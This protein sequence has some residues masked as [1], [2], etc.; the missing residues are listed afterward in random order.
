VV[1]VVCVV[2]VWC[3]C[4]GGCGCG[5]G[6][7]GVGG[8]VC[9]CGVVWY[10][11]IV[12]LCCGIGIVVLWCGGVVVRC[13]GVVLVAFTPT[14]TEASNPNLLV[15]DPWAIHIYFNPMRNITP[16]KDKMNQIQHL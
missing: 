1:C 7:V 3:E 12:V 4:G 10:C 13:R 5:C 11:G 15:Q 6:V 14:R 8:V 9:V 16:H 2:W